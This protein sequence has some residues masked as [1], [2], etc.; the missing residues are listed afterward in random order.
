MRIQDFIKQAGAGVGARPTSVW[1]VPDPL[2]YLTNAVGIG[3]GRS[4][5]E[6]C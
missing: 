1:S 2:P 5:D 4:R 6:V 3:T